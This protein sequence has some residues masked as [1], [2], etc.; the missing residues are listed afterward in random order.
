MRALSF[1]DLPEEI[2]EHLP[3]DEQISN[4]EKKR[5]H[6]SPKMICDQVLYSALDGV[7]DF[8]QGKTDFILSA[9]SRIADDDFNEDQA[10]KNNEFVTLRKKELQ[11]LGFHPLITG[12]AALLAR[13][14]G[15]RFFADSLVMKTPEKQK[16]KGIV[17]I[18][19][20]HI[21]PLVH[22]MLT[23]WIPLQD[24]E[25]D[26]GPLVYLDESLL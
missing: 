4:Y 16:S 20:R 19:A 24:C 15:T 26:M 10:I 3:N 7:K 12:T 11:N 5:W 14:S 6:I 1:A 9:Q 22:P 17:G 8:Y 18:Q 21:G 23:A 13:T 25:I 2:M